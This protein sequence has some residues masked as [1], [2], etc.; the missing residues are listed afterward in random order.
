MVN[1]SRWK[2]FGTPWGTQF[3]WLLAFGFS[4]GMP[5]A[6]VGSTLQ[7]WMTQAKVDLTWIGAFSLVSAPYT[8]KFLWAP[9]MDRFIPPFLGRRRGWILIAQLGVILGLVGLSSVH[10][11][12]DNQ[13]FLKNQ[14]GIIALLAFAVSFFSAS[15]DIAIDAFRTESLATSSYALGGAI[16]TFGY[17]FAMLFSGAFALILADHLSFNQ[18]YLLMAACMSVGVLTNFLVAEPE[19]KASRPHSLSQALVEPLREF[20]SRKGSLEMIAFILVYKLDVVL[21]LA[22]MTTFFLELGFSN[23][24]IG[25]VSKGFGLV[26]LLAGTFLGGIYSIRLG[27]KR[28]LLVFGLLQGF[29]G[30]C[31][32]LLARI[33]HHYPMM[34]AAISSENFFSGMGNAAYSAFIMSLCHPKFTA[35]QFA[36]LTS[37]MA[38][39]RVLLGSP[40][41][42]LA[43]SLGWESY[44]L[45]AGVMMLPGIFLLVFRYKNWGISRPEQEFS[46]SS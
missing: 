34:V 5:L 4:S 12:T 16:H 13:G 6:L 22:L 45:F 23:T 41:G 1:L 31:F 3:F 30:I 42:W 11:M 43:K 36:L 39:S 18:V 38:L 25:A 24:D 8:L 29:S 28:S 21:T 35:T 20:L 27:M 40:S 10:P 14:F 33:G 26:A 15:Q 17:R 37:L 19:M 32:F 46:Q 44:F 7:A 2:G 9:L